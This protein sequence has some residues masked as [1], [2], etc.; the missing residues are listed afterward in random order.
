MELSCCRELIVLA[1]RLNF[2][3]AA[4]QLYITQSALSK[5]VAAAEREVGFK[6]FERTTTRVALT[7]AG[8]AYIDGLH[9]VVDAYDD[10]LRLARARLNRAHVVRLVGP[11][12]NEEIS[13]LVYAAHKRLV[14]K[15]SN[16][17]ISMS[18]MGV[19]DTL[20]A[21]LND[22]ADLA[23]FFRYGRIER[24]LR[25]EHLFDVPFGVA[26]HET[27]PLARKTPLTF[28]DVVGC[29][30]LS[31]PVEGRAGYHEFVERVSRKHGI[32]PPADYAADGAFPAPIANNNVIVFGVYYPGYVRTGEGAVS[33]PLDDRSDVFDLCVACRKSEENPQVTELFEEIVRVAR[34]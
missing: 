2:S 19:R 18:D 4:A 26:C 30:M 1:D 7:E 28:A 5:H 3:D 23:V 25:V 17:R 16:M 6:L 27:H 15:G 22:A 8:R 20:D 24:K 14:S 12:M 31:Y 9:A 11:F 10:A 34:E 29:E 13:G 33:R 21:L 32:N